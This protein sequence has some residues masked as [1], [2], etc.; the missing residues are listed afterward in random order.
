MPISPQISLQL[1]TFTDDQDHEWRSTLALAQAMD[2]A[3]VDRVVV[4][5]HVVFGENPAAYSN[6]ALGGIAGGRQP[7]GPDGQWLEPLTVLTALAAMTTR[8][9]LGTAVLLAA[10]RRPAVLAKQVST[11]DVLSGGRVDLGVGVG[12]QRE[13]Y[14]AAGLPFERRGRLLDHTLEVCDALWTQ[15]RSS[16]RSPELSFE[17]IHQMPKPVQAGGVPIWVSGTVND[18]VARRLSRFGRGWIP[19]GPAA[20]DPAGAIAA[21]K[22]KL[23]DFGADP[24]DLQVLG[25]ATTVK[26]P[27][28]SVDIAATVASAPPLISAGVTDVR[29]TMAL[30]RNVNRATEL[31]SE[32]VEAFRAATC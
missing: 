3:G 30:P 16:Y 5:D 13:E 19:W 31:L 9:R 18:A 29:I 10:L 32:L 28:R 6:P 23:S 26:R 7:T 21:M 4:S 25:H 1:R 11:L 15:Q 22:D 24:T 17:T 14:E 8:I 20:A 2:A 27:D 12:W